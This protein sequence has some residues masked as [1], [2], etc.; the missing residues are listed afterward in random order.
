MEFSYLTLSDNHYLDNTRL[1]N[2]FVADIAAEALD[3]DELGMHL[4]WI[5]EE[6]TGQPVEVR[7]AFRRAI[8]LEPA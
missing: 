3:A 4:A 8:G 1:A 7:A 5:G 6:Q 2:Q